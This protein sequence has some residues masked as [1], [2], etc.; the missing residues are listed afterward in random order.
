MFRN[1]CYVVNAARAGRES[2]HIVNANLRTPYHPNP[3]HPGNL[4]MQLVTAGRTVTLC[5]L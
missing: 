1:R 3:W 2:T 5:G 4:I